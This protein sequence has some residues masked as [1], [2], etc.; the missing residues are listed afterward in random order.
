MINLLPPDLKGELRAAHA[1]VVLRKYFTT[2]LIALTA[3]VIIFGSAFYIN[4]TNTQGY[5]L[6]LAESEQ[7]L[8]S[9]K[10]TRAKTKTYNTNL[11][12][13]RQIFANEVKLSETIDQ[14]SSLLPPGSVL[15]D[16]SLGVQ[17]L[18]KPISI[19]AQVD[20]LEKAAVLKRNFE[21]SGLFTTVVLKDVISS[22]AST[23]AYPYTANLEVV[24]KPKAT[25]NTSAPASSSPAQVLPG[26]AP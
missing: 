8:A 15:S 23:V 25:K 2:S 16:I 5:K 7:N 9:L 14:L 13:A 12:N 17:Q 3:I 22:Q 10:G 11:A 20:T 4:Y 18:K 21:D 1:N 6:L 19:V 24:L 26:L